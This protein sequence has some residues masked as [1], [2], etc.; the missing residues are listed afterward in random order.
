MAHTKESLFRKIFSSLVYDLNTLVDAEKLCK[1]YKV[2]YQE[3]LYWVD[4]CPLHKAKLREYIETVNHE[5]LVKQSKRR[6][7]ED[8]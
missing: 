1:L 7:S 8:S 4:S 3:F 2:N 6:N 5:Q